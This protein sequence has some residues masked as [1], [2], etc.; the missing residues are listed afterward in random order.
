MHCVSARVQQMG[1]PAVGGLLPR[2]CVLCMNFRLRGIIHFH[3][4]SSL[5]GNVCLASPFAQH[6][7]FVD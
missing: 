7:K 5:S 2:H 4:L 6:L 1:S 3:S